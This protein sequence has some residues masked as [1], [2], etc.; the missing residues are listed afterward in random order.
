MA[1][2]KS[3]ARQQFEYTLASLLEQVRYVS[4]MKGLRSDIIQSVYNNAIFTT[5]AALE[6]YIKEVLE[7]W[8]D[9]LSRNNGLLS[10]LPDEAVCFTLFKNQEKNF[11]NYISHG[12]ESKLVSQIGNNKEFLGRFYISTSPVEKLITSQQLIMD[13]KYPSEKN[14][15][16]LFSRF[17]F[18][19]IFKDMEKKGKKDYTKLLQSFSDTRTELAHSFTV[20]SLTK[21]TTLDKI[22]KVTELVKI[23]D[24]ILFSYIC[25][26]SGRAFWKTEWLSI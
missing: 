6:D 24:R 20:I 3:A 22:N 5:S 19:N 4:N 13:K 10:H 8:I 14:I 18:K 25:S 12:S 9:M 26:T 1:Y 11:I 17:G 23:L 15:K 2:T 7:D 16:Q 21:V